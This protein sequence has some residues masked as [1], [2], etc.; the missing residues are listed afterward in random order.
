MT[1]HPTFAAWQHLA[2]TELSVAGNTPFLLDDPTQAWLVLSGRVEVFCVGLTG[3]HPGGPRHHYATVDPGDI[4]FGVDIGRHGQGLGLLAVGAVGT[5]LLKVA[6]AQLRTLPEPPVEPV[7]RWVTSLSRAVSRLIVPTPRADVILEPGAESRLAAGGRVRPHKGVVWVRHL[8]GRSVFI[9]MEE[10]ADTREASLFPLASDAY[11]QALEPVRLATLDTAAA[12]ASDEGWQGLESFHAP[13]FRCESVNARLAMADELNR[14]TERALRDRRDR[15]VAFAG[16]AEVIRQPSAAFGDITTD[17]PLL[18]ACTLIGRHMGLAIQAPPPPK[19]SEA[20]LDPLGDIVRASRIR[21]RQVILKGEWWTE[22][23][24]PMLAYMEPDRRPVAII[25]LRPGVF[26]LHDPEARTRTAV[27]GAVAETLAGVAHTFYRPFPSTR[28]SPI[29]LL[30]FAM[31]GRRADLVRLV[32][33]GSFG[34]LLALVPAYFLG[35]LVDDVIPQGALG[36]LLQLALVLCVVTVTTACFNVVRHFCL[37]RLETTMSTSVQPALWD[38]L[39]TLPTAFFRHYTA[40]DLS[41]RVAAVDEVRRMVSGAT[42]SSMVTSIFSVFLVAQLF[43]YSPGLAVWSTALI[44]LAFVL[45]CTLALLRVRLQRPTLQ[46]EGRIAGLVL[47]LLTGISKLRVAGAEN[48]AFS[49]WAREFARQKRLE[50]SG[51]VL[52][53]WATAHGGVVPVVTS[54]AVFYLVV[55]L[56]ARAGVAGVAPMS[57][58]DFVAFN[59]AL[60]MLLSQVLRLGMTLMSVLGVIPL[61]ERARPVL[62]AEPEVTPVMADPG[63]L[64][65]RIDVDH[66][67]FRYQADGP[68]VLDDVSVHARPGEYIALVGPSGSGKSTLV[69]L[70]LGLEVAER[71]SINFDG[72]DISRLDVQK[73]R[74][75]I[76]VVMQ[77]GK[78]R[79][80]SLLQ[81]IVGAWPL[82]IDDAWEAARQAGLE[83]DL[84]EMPMGMHTVVQQGGPTLSGGQRQ[85]LM[86]ARAI[87]NRPRVVV[88]DE[89][90]S[91]LDNRTQAIVTRSLERLQAT[92]IAVAHRLSTIIG[93]D[94]IYVLDKGRVVQTGTYEEL[95]AQEGLFAE[96]IKRQLA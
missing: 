52:E 71:G 60:A 83:D 82:T 57:P 88:F 78:I 31:V 22:D 3:G 10:L 44:L 21:A 15:Q 93:A 34:G 30:R 4:L 72:R 58:G 46:V 95:A 29:A 50:F 47:Q 24:A 1:T 33:V 2:G 74:R 92:R 66:V 43:Y 8:E 81:N 94:R 28:L 14:L 75:K 42:I 64:A 27:T 65:G 45:A 73:L 39:L 76:G 62:E 40:G 87:V 56:A 80:G 17:D 25:P 49:L 79:E 7:D 16:L 20:R 19:A 23:A 77:T 51:G 59:T 91:A 26:E 13:V 85:R 32:L 35:I 96:L 41:Q 18:A 67:S 38:R 84:R 90:T 63:E 69:R 12:L 61:F 53:I 9:G 55:S 70:L 48:R 68:L 36:Q 6:V 54:M 86:I 11:L 89:A 5:R 37:L